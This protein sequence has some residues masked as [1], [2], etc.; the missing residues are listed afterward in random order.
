ML[1]VL[2]NV[3]LSVYKNEKIDT[4]INKIILRIF[5]RKPDIKLILKSGY[6]DCLIKTIEINDKID[7][8]YIDILFF[9]CQYIPNYL[10]H[11]AFFNL[12]KLLTTKQNQK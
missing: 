2:S 6:L 1:S 4:Y 12:I 8:S 3:V 10:N 9:Y 7:D 5:A 11:R